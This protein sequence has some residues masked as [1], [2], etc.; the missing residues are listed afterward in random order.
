MSGPGGDAAIQANRQIL[1][2]ER[3]RTA[4]WRALL[5]LALHDPSSGAMQYRKSAVR[6]RKWESAT[7]NDA[8]QSPWSWFRAKIRKLGSAATTVVRPLVLQA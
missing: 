4:M 3:P 6:T 7:A 2:D 8:R 5:R 1:T